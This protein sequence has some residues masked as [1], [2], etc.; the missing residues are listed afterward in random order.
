MRQG[1]AISFFLLSLNYY[2]KKKIFYSLILFLISISFQYSMVIPVCIFLFSSKLKT[3]KLPII[4]FLFFS[5]LSIFNFNILS[6]LNNKITLINRINYVLNATWIEYRTGFRIDFFIFNTFFVTLGLYFFKQ[7]INKIPEYKTYLSSY[8]FTSSIFFLMFPFPYS[9]RFGLLSW[10][11]IPFILLPFFHEIKRFK[12]YGLL[13]SYAIIFSF[14]I[15][16]M[17][18]ENK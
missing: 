16:F 6:I 12:K 4:C 2:K 13:I 7:S 15:F 8:L 14:N 5:V 11:F 3:I 10:I 9:D 18:L 17:I 1:I